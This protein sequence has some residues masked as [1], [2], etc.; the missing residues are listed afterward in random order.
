MRLPKLSGMGPESSLPARLRSESVAMSPRLEGIGPT[1]WLPAR[2]NFL[3]CHVHPVKESTKQ[4][5]G[6]R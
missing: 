5:Y 1:S 2:Y 3:P 6:V 4:D